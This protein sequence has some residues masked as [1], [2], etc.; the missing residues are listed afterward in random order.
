[1]NDLDTQLIEALREFFQHEVETSEGVLSDLDE[2]VD[3]RAEAWCDMY[4]DQY[5][6]E[7]MEGLID[8][9]VTD[10]LNYMLSQVTI[11]INAEAELEY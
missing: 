11:N 8:Q 10:Q 5:I 7:K 6:T 4:L 9:R 3:Q 2:M 1:M